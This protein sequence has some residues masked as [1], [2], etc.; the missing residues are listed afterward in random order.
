MCG[1]VEQLEARR[2]NGCDPSFT[3]TVMQVIN[4]RTQGARLPTWKGIIDGPNATGLKT[5]D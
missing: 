5:G 1:D 4:L 2:M 3:A